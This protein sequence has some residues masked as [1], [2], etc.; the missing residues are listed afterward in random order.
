MP[1][2]RRTLV[3]VQAIKQRPILKDSLDLKLAAAN[4]RACKRS[5]CRQISSVDN[6]TGKTRE[7]EYWVIWLRGDWNYHIKICNLLSNILVITLNNKSRLIR[8]WLLHGALWMA[9]WQTVCCK[10]MQHWCTKVSKTSQPVL[11]AGIIV[12][13]Q[14]CMPCDNWQTVSLTSK[15]PCKSTVYINH[16][17]SYN[18]EVFSHF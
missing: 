14:C 7:G 16:I 9:S 18:N 13:H 10:D 17:K 5:C 6:W 1:G 8:H 3:Y 2:H 12:V 4:G 15:T 11:Y